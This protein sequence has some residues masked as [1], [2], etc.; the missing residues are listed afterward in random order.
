M[1]IMEMVWIT[2]VCRTCPLSWSE[3]HRAPLGLVFKAAI[4]STCSDCKED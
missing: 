2:F 3:K 4:F 1:K